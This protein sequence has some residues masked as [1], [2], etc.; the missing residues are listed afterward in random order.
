VSHSD[1]GT[2]LGIV[3]AKIYVGETV[4]SRFMICWHALEMAQSSQ[5]NFV[6]P[7]TGSPT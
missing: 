3:L 1:L 7:K 4:R 2:A 5:I 6:P